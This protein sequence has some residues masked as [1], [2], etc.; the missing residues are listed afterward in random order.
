MSRVQ[1]L[2]T[3]QVCRDMRLPGDVDTLSKASAFFASEL[4]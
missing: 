1:G 4:R 2:N 3:I